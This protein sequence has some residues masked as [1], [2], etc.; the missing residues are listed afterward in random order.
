MDQHQL[1]RLGNFLAAL[2]IYPIQD[3]PS[4]QLSVTWVDDRYVARP[5][6]D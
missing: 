3:D 2:T 5:V 6:T 1:A 4:I